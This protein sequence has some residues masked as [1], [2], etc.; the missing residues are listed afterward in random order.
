MW[1]FS[2]LSGFGNRRVQ[3]RRQ[4]LVAAGFTLTELLVVISLMLILTT[5][6]LLRQQQFNSATVLRSLSYSIALSMR[7]AQAYGT[8]IRES[9]A[10]AF[11]TS[12]AARAYGV[13]FSTATPSS[14]V[15]FA[16][17]NNNGR[18]E[19]A[20][21]IVVQT[22]NLSTGYTIRTLSA[23]TSTNVLRASPAISDLT[24]IFRRPNPDACVSTSL[25]TGACSV[26]PSGEQYSSAIIQIAGSDET[27]SITVLV[28]GQISVGGKGS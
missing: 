10:G 27:R 9:A 11:D 3:T 23:T 6:F 24:L 18:Y 4:S 15:L 21:D 17:A 22:F 1:I 20:T 12:T 16:D 2:Q 14:Y 7:Q 25:S 13:Y 19:S 26:T 28:T 5:V 8:S